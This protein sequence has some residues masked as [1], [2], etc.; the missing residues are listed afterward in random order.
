MSDGLLLPN[1]VNIEQTF[2]EGPLA[3]TIGL[4]KA[5]NSGIAVLQIGGA[6]RDEQLAA[7]IL[8][9]TL[10]HSAGESTD[11][12]IAT[13]FELADEIMAEGRR[14]RASKTE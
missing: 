8:G 2:V 6:Y 4:S 3:T 10:A 14:R 12:L 13:A 5:G 7:C 9:G 1:Q 11:Q